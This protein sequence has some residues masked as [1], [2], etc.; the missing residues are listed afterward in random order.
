[1]WMEAAVAV[2]RQSLYREDIPMQTQAKICKYLHSLGWYYELQL[3]DC[4]EH[5]ARDYLH[6]DSNRTCRRAL[7][8]TF[9]DTIIWALILWTPGK[10]CDIYTNINIGIRMKVKLHRTYCL[11]TNLIDREFTQCLWSVGVGNP[12]PSNTCPRWP[13]QFLHVI[14]TRFIPKLLSSCLSTVPGNSS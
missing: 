7:I 13:P 3:T 4:D 2:V 9:V 10:S 11:G 14:S 1:M 6:G 8:D 5:N 12:S